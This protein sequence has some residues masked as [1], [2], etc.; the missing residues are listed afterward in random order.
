MA[1]KSIGYCAAT[2]KTALILLCEVALGNMNELLSHDYN[3]ASLPSGKHSTKGCGRTHP[4][5]SIIENGVEIPLGK[6]V[7]SK[8]KVKYF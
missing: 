4:G 2:K 1:S 6:P 7:Q 3:A 5:K 8:E